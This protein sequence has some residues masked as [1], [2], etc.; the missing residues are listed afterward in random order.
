MTLRIYD[1]ATKKA[2]AGLLPMAPGAFVETTLDCFLHLPEAAQPKFWIRDFTA[3]QYNAMRAALQAGGVDEQ[4]VNKTLQEGALVGWDNLPNSAFEELKFSA[5]AIA[6]LPFLWK[7]ALYWK[8]AK[9]CSPNK[10]E[11]E[12]LG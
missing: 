8:A 9:L 10:V 11:K 1:E 6:E 7:E 5:E 2:L 4:L 3:P 12:A